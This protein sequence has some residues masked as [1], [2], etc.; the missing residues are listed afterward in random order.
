L[1]SGTAYPVWSMI[2]DAGG[3]ALDG[4]AV[5]AS[6]TVGVPVDFAVSPLDAWSAIQST[7]WSFGDGT[8]AIDELVSHVYTTP[9]TYNVTASSSDVLGNTSSQHSTIVIAA[10]PATRTPAVPITPLTLHVSQAHRRWRE[11]TRRAAP[12]RAPVNTYFSVT[13]NKAAR[14]TLTFWQALPGRRSHGHCR[15][16]DATNRN[17]PRCLRTARRGSLSLLIPAAGRRRLGF[18]GR[19]G[20]R[21]LGLGHYTVTIRATGAGATAT[22]RL[23]FTITN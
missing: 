1:F 23:S 2:N 13:V 10:A 9:G 7:R 20:T 22:G 15:T 12:R 16:I 17:R 21:R 5:P 11:R 19:I 4:L 3:P 18:T 14:V 6:G 8:T